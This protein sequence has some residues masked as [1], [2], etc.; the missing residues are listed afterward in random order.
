M[1]VSM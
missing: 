1:S